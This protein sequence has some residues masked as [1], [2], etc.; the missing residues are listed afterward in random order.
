M[1]L[2]LGVLLGVA[3]CLLSVAEAGLKPGD[4]EGEKE[5]GLTAF[6]FTTF[7]F[8]SFFLVGSVSLRFVA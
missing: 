7:F 5:G 3:S 8:L 4:C 6:I 1:K 2:Y